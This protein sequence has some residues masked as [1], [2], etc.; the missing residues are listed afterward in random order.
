[1]SDQ[2]I[3]IACLAAYNNGILHGKWIDCTSLE[4]IHEGIKE[5]L[6]TSP[7]NNNPYPCEEWAIHD[8]EGLGNSITE[9]TSPERIMEIVEFFEEVGNAEL[10]EGLLDYRGGNI[11]DARRLFESYHGEYKDRGD[12]AY[13]LAEETGDLQQVP[14]WLTYHIDFDAVARDLFM[15]GYVD[16]EVDGKIHVFSEN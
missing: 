14:Q 13:S 9:S 2:R 15:D 16:I 8:Y 3:Y 11:D 1:M 10:A 7:E 5:V 6:N 12:F 4:E